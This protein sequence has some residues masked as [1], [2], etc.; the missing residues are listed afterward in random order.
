VVL[1]C[2]GSA[3]GRSCVTLVAV[4][5]APPWTELRGLWDLHHQRVT[6]AIQHVAT[7]LPFPVRAWHSDNGSE[8]VNAALLGWCQRQGVRFTRGRPYRKNDPAWFEQRNGLLVRRLIGYDRYSS[9]AA[10]TT[11]QRLYA[12]LPP[13]PPT[14]QQA[15]SR[16]S[17]PQALRRPPDPVPAGP[18]GG[19]PHPHSARRAPYPVRGARSYRPRPPDRAHPGRALEAR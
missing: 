18:R 2:G 7:R 11:L 16:Q 10:C 14:P 12:L 9:R 19:D 15:P 1:L 5:A 6:G 17:C 4:D 8:F 3:A 13:R